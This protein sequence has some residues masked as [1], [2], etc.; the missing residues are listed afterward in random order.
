LVAVAT[1]LARAVAVALATA[2]LTAVASAEPL[3]PCPAESKLHTQPGERHCLPFSFGNL[4]G[5]FCPKYKQAVAV[6]ANE[7]V[8]AS[9]VK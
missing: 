2:T 9:C 4:K 8:Q 5:K 3:E 6:A 1:A 7:R